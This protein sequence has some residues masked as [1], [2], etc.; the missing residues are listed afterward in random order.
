MQAQQA[1]HKRLSLSGNYAIMPTSA[2]MEQ[3]RVRHATNQAITVIPVSV[4][5]PSTHRKES[6]LQKI[7]PG[8][9]LTSVMMLTWISPGFSISGNRP[10]RSTRG[11]RCLRQGDF[12]DGLYPVVA[13]IEAFHQLDFF[14]AMLMKNFLVLGADLIHCFEA[15]GGEGR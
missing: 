8:E 4:S 11:K 2:A 1:E 7:F 6:W 5:S 12:F 13:A 9:H 14:A 10:G 3:G 15:I